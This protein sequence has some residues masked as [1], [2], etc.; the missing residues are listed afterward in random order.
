[1][2]IFERNKFTKLG[3]VLANECNV[4][5][6]HEIVKLPPVNHNPEALSI[7]V[8]SDSFCLSKN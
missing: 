2:Q 8:L 5:F 1:M 6:E 7:F 3:I 4:I